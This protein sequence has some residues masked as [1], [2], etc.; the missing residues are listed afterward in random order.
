V[1][2]YK[3][4]FYN[5]QNNPYTQDT[6]KRLGMEGKNFAARAEQLRAPGKVADFVVVL[7]DEPANF[8]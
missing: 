5:D 1:A 3:A 4:Y 7:F 6:Q 8:R 2:G